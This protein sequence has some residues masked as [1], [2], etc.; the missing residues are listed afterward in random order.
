MAANYTTSGPVTLSEQQIKALH[1]KLREMRHD[2]N[3]KLTN[4]LLAA[5]LMKLRPES[6][7]DRL[8]V[9][10]E[11]NKAVKDI[12]DRFSREFEATLGLMRQ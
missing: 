4:M 1:E 5:E 9:L 7:G 8:N 2:V 11:Q 10:N 6:A 12:L 3:N